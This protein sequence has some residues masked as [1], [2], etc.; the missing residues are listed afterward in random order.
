ARA[1]HRLARRMLDIHGI[2]VRVRGP[3]PS[4]PALLV[5]NHLGYLDPLVVGALLPLAA[6]AKSELAAWPLL[7][8]VAA[9]M[10]APFIPR[11]S[12]HE[13]AVV[14]RRALRRLAAGI[15]VL[16]FPEGTP[17]DGSGPLLPF[18]RGLFGIARRAGVP[19]VPLG[20]R[21]DPAEAAWVG[22]EAFLPHYWR[23]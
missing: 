6:V 12:P 7:G 16:T 18:R 11:S 10:G 5:C 8:R 2:Q 9:Q 21:L 15:R 19:V 22:G 23:M 3:I 20:L 1:A 17:T 13:G 14:L 4:G